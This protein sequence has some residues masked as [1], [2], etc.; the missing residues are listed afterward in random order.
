[1]SLTGDPIVIL[2]SYRSGT[3]LLSTGLVNMGLYMGEE[4]ALFPADD[5]N[6]DGHWELKDMMAAHERILGA[7]RTDYHPTIWIPQ[8]WDDFPFAV[9]MVRDLRGLLT[10]H[11]DGKVQWGW[12]EPATSILLPLY[13]KALVEEGVAGRYLICVRH[14]KSV[15][16]SMMKRFVRSAT[17]LWSE[18]ASK[19]AGL[20]ERLMCMWVSYT[21]TSLRESKGTMRELV[22]YERYLQNPR[23]YADR[24]AEH[25]LP[26]P[27]TDAQKDAAASIVKPSLSHTLFKPE[28][29]L[30]NWPA[31]IAK[32]YDLCLRADN[33]AAQ[34]RQGGFDSEIEELW[35]EWLRWRNMILPPTLPPSQIRIKWD[36]GE[37]FEKYSPTGSWQTIRCSF[38][39]AARSVL[40]DPFHAPCRMW[41]RSANWND[42]SPAEIQ[43]GPG[44]V[45]EELGGIKRLSISGPDALVAQPP[46]GSIELKM[47]V[48][49]Q[50][51]EAILAGILS[52]RRK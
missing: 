19:Q 17:E 33:D 28:E 45:L 32:V 12:K 21:L 26:W 34:F 38:D 37:R 49:L 14:P 31:M 1:M 36:G 8:N 4:S 23:S 40:I 11:F 18:D 16:A 25:L 10:K 35:T 30:E 41:V 22:C 7:F 29:G 9:N 15:V 3:S 24:I 2:G 51:N 39:A 48:L 50:S 43:S 20:E 46:T 44:G 13:K 6:P 52:S 5:F 42:G 27:V 47:E